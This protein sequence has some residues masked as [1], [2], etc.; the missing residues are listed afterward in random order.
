MWVK[1]EGKRRT[2]LAAE[3]PAKAS[4]QLYGLL[5]KAAAA[6]RAQIEAGE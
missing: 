1:V 6:Y 4:A 5:P 3:T 2:L